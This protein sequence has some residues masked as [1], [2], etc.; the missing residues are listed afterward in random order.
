M[1]NARR[2]FNLIPLIACVMPLVGMAQ[3]PHAHATKL[4]GPP[5]V[6]TAATPTPYID[7]TGRLWLAWAH[8]EHVYVNYSDDLGKHFSAPVQVNQ[9]PQQIHTNGE[10]RPK[11]AV[12]DQGHIFVAY[13]QKLPT[14]FT[15]HIR[16]SRSADLG[17]SFSEPY[18]VN[19]DEQEISHRFVSMLLDDKQQIH[20]SWLDGRDFVAAK[21]AGT[22]YA[23][24]AL[25]YAR[26]VDRGQSFE[27][28]QKLAD[29]TC[30]CCRIA[31]DL[32]GEDPVYFWRHIY[33]NQNN[34]VS[35]DH[36]LLSLNHTL[37]TYRVTFEN[38]NVEGCPHH[39]PSLSID[40]AQQRMH[41]TWF[42][43]ANDIPGIYYAY[44]DDGGKTQHGLRRLNTD[45]SQLTHPAVL[46]H[47]GKVWLV[48]KA[49]N[50][51]D[52]QLMMQRSDDN[53]ASWLA[54]QSIASTSAESDHPLLIKHGD[55]IYASWQTQAD[56]YRLIALP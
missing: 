17:K 49:F 12:D 7:H 6:A 28:D 3:A 38:W 43:H 34:T 53:G 41:M 13:T 25:Y 19:D 36:A 51:S 11:I 14:R 1:V 42:N 31:A 16:F 5:S 24:S 15:G 8:G 20:L 30:Q 50:G 44:T 18:I 26:S 46:Q 23:G 48:W 40:D 54:A 45:D 2:A 27:A 22:A 39:G 4:E 21:Q 9:T 52:T 29:N 35:R 37:N 33:Q 55:A 32:N 10:A 47:Q 56:G